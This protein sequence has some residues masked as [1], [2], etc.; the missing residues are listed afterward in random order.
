M[1]LTK[2]DSTFKDILNDSTAPIVVLPASRPDVQDA[3]NVQRANDL[4]L[5]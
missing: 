2:T 4:A 5:T 3:A 1:L